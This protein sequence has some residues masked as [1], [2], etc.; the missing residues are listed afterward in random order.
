MIPRPQTIL[1]KLLAALILLL[2]STHVA[3]GQPPAG[4]GGQLGASHP[5]N[6]PPESTPRSALADFAWLEGRWQGEWGPRTAEQVWMAPSGSTMLG[7]FRLVE[8]DKTLVIELF[9][10]I[11]KPDGVEFRIRHFTPELL[12]WEKASS[13]V[14]VLA[15]HD[16]MKAVFENPVDGQPKHAVL[17]RVD[18][19]TYVSRSEIV[20]EKGD[21][22]VVEITYHRPKPPAPPPS[23]G[24]GGR[25]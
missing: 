18:G 25:R 3:Q 19:D 15:S 11:E 16:P 6:V 1:V 5:V 23:G 10:L 8:N 12:P 4:S 13:T 22:Q 7:T 14:L 20:P 17:T 24:S 2:G 21:T 9:V